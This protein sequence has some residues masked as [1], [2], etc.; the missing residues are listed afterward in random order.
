MS[1]A[2]RARCGTHVNAILGQPVRLDLTWGAF[3]RSQTSAALRKKAA[4]HPSALVWD[5]LNGEQL[6]VAQ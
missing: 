4:D 2:L 6:A 3:H 5:D 1:F